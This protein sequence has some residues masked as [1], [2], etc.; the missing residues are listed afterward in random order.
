M[1]TLL[2][3]DAVFFGRLQDCSSVGFKC[4]LQSGHPILVCEPRYGIEA[5]TIWTDLGKKAF[6]VFAQDLDHF[7]FGHVLRPPNAEVTSGGLA[8][9]G[10][11]LSYL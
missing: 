10:Y 3:L 1:P 4:F 7:L 2:L 11:F 5:I 6:K 9:T 8:V